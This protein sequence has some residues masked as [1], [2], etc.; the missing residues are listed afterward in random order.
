MDDYDENSMTTAATKF[1]LTKLFDYI[2]FKILSK[3]N[4][5]RIKALLMIVTYNGIIDD[6]N[7]NIMEG[8]FC[9]FSS[10]FLWIIHMFLTYEQKCH[11]YH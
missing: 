7:N 5:M 4:L 10:L 11:Q 1:L 2:Y 6:N 8:N 9:Q 3:N